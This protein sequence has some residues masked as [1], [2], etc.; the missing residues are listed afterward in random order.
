[1]QS[2]VIGTAPTPTPTRS[3]PLVADRLRKLARRVALVAVAVGAGFV[4]AALFQGPAAAG[5]TPDWSGAGSHP[6]IDALVEPVARLTAA[7]R[8]GPGRQPAA[9]T[10]DRLRA[11]LTGAADGAAAHEQ[12]PSK[13]PRPVTAPPPASVPPPRPGAT[14]APPATERGKLRPAEVARTAHR[15]VH[16]GD[17]SRPAA[18]RPRQPAA[19]VADL[20]VAPDLTAVADLP[21]AHVLDES[22]VVALVTAPLPHVVDLV[23][24][25]PIR[26][27]VTALLGV[28][29]AVLPPDLGVAVVPAA[30]PAPRV[31]PA[32]GPVAAGPVTGPVRAAPVPTSPAV[33]ALAP[34][35]AASAPA[36][37]AP[38]A[39]AVADPASPTVPTGHRT[40]RES[41]TEAGELPVRP[42]APADQDA[43]GADNR[44]TPAPGLA[45]PLD[46]QT[47][48]NAGRPRHVVPLPV[49]SR[50]FSPVPRP[51]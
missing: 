49:E 23:N 5:G 50:T 2:P 51:G 16:R 18:D 44:K 9:G 32:L 19:A 39:T 38:P 35:P 14:V 45:R 13:K 46:R 6:Q 10:D 43:A 7:Q 34:T 29:D 25:L 12:A 37:S 36:P 4:V 30:T 27:V 3:T 48:E 31:P 17:R 24:T 40:H 42:V 20:P 1:M 33:P 8:P 11:P 26:P 15:I 41:V 28:A 47:R 22:P 21:A